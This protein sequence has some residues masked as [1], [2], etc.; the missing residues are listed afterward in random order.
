MP[1]LLGVSL[2]TIDRWVKN[3]TL[4]RPVKLTDN[5]TAFDAVEI[6]NWLAERRG[7]VA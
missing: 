5:V 3:G 4:P 7:K 6:N 1:E 2:P